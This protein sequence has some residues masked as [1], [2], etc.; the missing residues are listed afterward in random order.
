MITYVLG[1]IF[2]SPATVLINTVNTVGVMGKGIAKDFKTYFPEMFDAYQKLCKSGEFT[3]G[4]LFYFRAP[5]KSILN[6]PTKRHWK[7]KSRIEDI[8]AGLAAFVAK[9]EQYSIQSI[10]FPQLGCGNGELDWEQQI[11]PLMEKYLRPLPIAIY[12]HLYDGS[13][14]F[15]E[16]RSVREMKRWLREQPESLPFQEVWDDL[17][18]AIREAPDVE[19]NGN[20]RLDTLLS[21][22][23]EPALVLN[24]RMDKLTISFGELRTI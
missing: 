24:Q 13:Q 19:A 17:V 2:I 1:D 16:H 5:H 12:I 6:F 18:G 4:S 7:Q 20:W 23:S 22:D 9:Y 8:E 11:Q 10:A 15:L 21:D 14:E 3:I